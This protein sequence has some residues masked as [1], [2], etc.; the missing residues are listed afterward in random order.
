MGDCDKYFSNLSSKWS[1]EENK[2]FEV[3][4]AIIDEKSPKRWEWIA[5]MTGNKKTAEEVQKH[6]EILL[7]DVNFIETCLEM[8]DVGTCYRQD[9][10]QR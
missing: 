10:E 9:H 7:E 5:L 4:L 3:A 2:L 1:Q 8:A 6:F